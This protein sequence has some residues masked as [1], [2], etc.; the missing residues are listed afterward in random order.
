MSEVPPEQPASDVPI[1][2]ED[3]LMVAVAKPSG[4]FVHR[5]EAD[6][7]AS[8]FVVQNVRDQLGSFV[9]PVHRLDRA[10]SGILLLAK[11]SE[12]AAVLSQMFAERRIKKRYL[13]LVRGFTADEG[14]VDRPLVSSKGRGK[15]AGHPQTVPQDALTNYRTLARFE[16]PFASSQHPTTRCSIV[17]ALPKTGRYHQIRRHLSGLFHPIIG[18]SE[19]GDTKLNRKFIEHL[20]VTRLMLAAVQVEFEHPV[21]KRV[22]SI[23]CQPADSFQQVIDRLEQQGRT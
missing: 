10:T 18:D 5:S 22:L 9:Y 16:L 1:L 14:I 21:T 11:N 19:H 3:D 12:S 15:P 7:S 2:Y 20:G 6:R 13:T 4:M 8:E 23:E 17:E